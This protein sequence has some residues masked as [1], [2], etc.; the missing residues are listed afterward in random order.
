MKQKALA[1]YYSQTGQLRDII[2]NFMHPFVERYQVDYLEIKT[3]S[4]TFPLTLDAFFDAFPE[5]VLGKTCQIS[6]NSCDFNEYEIVVLGFQPW[7]VHLSVPFNS[8]VQT[9]DFRNTIKGKT[10]FLVTDCRSTWRNTLEFV[11][12]KVHQFGG[13]VKGKFVFRDVSE[14][15]IAGAFTLLNWL[16]KGKKDR[17][18]NHYSLPG[19]DMETIKNASQSGETAL[20]IH[21]SKHS[22]YNELENC[23]IIPSE[24][25]KEFS[26]RGYE[27]HIIQ[28]FTKWAKYV[29]R[30]EKWRKWRLSI[31]KIWIFFSIIFVAPFIS[32]KAKKSTN[33]K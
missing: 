23:F 10:V 14:G 2:E 27:E 30:N 19:V 17:M 33:S 26:S 29:T 6:Y 22:Q 24:N 25:D 15:N 32:K 20:N 16:K 3:D 31:F 4:Y 8:Y 13:V 1:V 21:E 28:Y 7:F 9:E 11:S 5:S 18:F 12:D